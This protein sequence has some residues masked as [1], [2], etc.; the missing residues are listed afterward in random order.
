MKKC[1]G[2]KISLTFPVFPYYFNIS[3]K[4][5]YQPEAVIVAGGW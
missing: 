5:A 2:A 1:V 4:H 3:V